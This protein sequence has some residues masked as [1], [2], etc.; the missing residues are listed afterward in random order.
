MVKVFED[1]FSELQTDMVAICLE[2]AHDKADNVYIY[3]SIEDNMFSVGFFYKINGKILKRHEINKENPECDVTV[4]MQKQVM[5]ILM[6]DLK[7]IQEKFIQ[8]D[9]EMPTEMKLIY[10]VNTNKMSADY[11][12]EKAIS[13]DSS[14]TAYDMEKKWFGQLEV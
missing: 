14:I 2:Y 10:D 11:N 6:D 4:G 3:C 1:Y 12:Y 9:R 13:G 7:K 5:Q 8:F